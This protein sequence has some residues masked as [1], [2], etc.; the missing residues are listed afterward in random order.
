VRRLAILSF[1]FFSSLAAQ[2]VFAKRVAPV[3]AKDAQNFPKQSKVALL[4]GVSA[5]P[6]ASGFENLH[7]AAKDVKELETTLTQQGY[8]VSLLMDA[9]ATRGAIVRT[10]HQV[11]E[12]VES[13]NGTLLFY[14][15][16]HGYSIGSQPFLAP[17]SASEDDLERE[18]LAVDEVTKIMAASKVQ[19]KV[20][21]LDACRSESKVKGA[22]GRSFSSLA[23]ASGFLIFNST[24]IGGVSYESDSLG[25][26]VFS[27]FVLKGLKGAAAGADGLVTFRDLS[28]YVTDSMVSWGLV[29]HKEQVPY[30]A[31]GPGEVTG[32]FLLAA[33]VPKVPVTAV[34]ATVTQ[35][36]IQSPIMK[37][38]EQFFSDKLYTQ[39]LPLYQQAAASD[40]L[41][42]FRL[43]MFYLTGAGVTRDYQQAVLWL[44][45]AADAGN[46]DA[47][48]GI[49]DMYFYG[50]GFP[51][52][53]QESLTW[54]RKAADMGQLDAMDFIG[55]QYARGLGVKQDEEQALTW[56]QKAAAAGSADAMFNVGFHYQEGHG[57]PQD[58]K[59]ALA[60]FLKAADAGDSKAIYNVAWCYEKGLGV[61]QDYGQAMIWLRKAA[62]AGNLKAINSVGEFYRDGRG[63]KQDYEQA[64]IW[65]RRG[66]AAGGPNATNSIGMLYEK[67]LGV[68][69]DRNQAIE[70][71]RKA[72]AMKNENAK[73][74]L[75]RLG[76]KP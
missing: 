33:D 46:A 67:G 7:Y 44:R 16:G 50:Q 1:L 8:T 75:E 42:M 71:Y 45:K 3:D 13:N 27:A 57:V 17:V 68:K 72:A 34:P 55:V 43:G 22:N 52:D 53:Y 37:R 32:E 63:V 73:E 9:D 48:K 70:W 38:A 69:A 14:F 4:V 6:S 30:E 62:E 51:K 12:T 66:S 11:A 74:N 29:N 64:M 24:K 76:V 58:Y 39:A 10:L 54:F 21:M 47:A 59:Q 49:G 31:V 5:Y 61:A 41:A 15:S 19:R 20:L 65:F 35:P 25:H 56:Y 23:A 40:S 18:G 26:G 2:G 36:Y 60:W 28:A